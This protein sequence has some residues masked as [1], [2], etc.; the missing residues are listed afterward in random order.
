MPGKE[1]EVF[2][3]LWVMT[4]RSLARL[5][6]QEKPMTPEERREMED[7][8]NKAT[9]LLKGQFVGHPRQQMEK[10]V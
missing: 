7:T 3:P 10:T 4:V 8:L 2:L 1:R 9:A 6:E 5:L